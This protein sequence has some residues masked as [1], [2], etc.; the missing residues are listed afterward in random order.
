MGVLLEDLKNYFNNTPKDI[1]EKEWKEKAYLDDIGPDVMEYFEFV[2]GY[3]ESDITYGK[4]YREDWKNKVI[5][6]QL[7]DLEQKL[8]HSNILVDN[9]YNPNKILIQNI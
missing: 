9:Q 6:S 2:K 3:Y 5:F 7:R 1:L 4:Y 8:F